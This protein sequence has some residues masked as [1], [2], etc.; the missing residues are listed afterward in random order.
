[1]VE[2]PGTAPG[3][4]KLI[5]TA[6]YHHSYLHNKDFIAEEYDEIKKKMREKHSL[7]L[8]GHRT[9]ISLEA[10]FWSHIKRLANEESVSLTYFIEQIDAKRGKNNLSSALRLRVLKDLEINT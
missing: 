4:N 6:I 2:T 10:E 3:S 9:S 7:T 1:M 8:Q 5:S